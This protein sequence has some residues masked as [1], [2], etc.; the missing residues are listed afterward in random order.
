MHTLPAEPLHADTIPSP[1][2][3]VS[4]REHVGSVASTYGA[5]GAIRIDAAPGAVTLERRGETLTFTPDLARSLAELL[6]RAAG[7]A[8]GGAVRR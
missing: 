3:T 6:E 7:L 5:L 2:L 8:C 4:D 1:E